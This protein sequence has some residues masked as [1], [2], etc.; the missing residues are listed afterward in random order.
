MDQRIDSGLFCSGTD[1]DEDAGFRVVDRRRRHDE[2]EDETGGAEA[3]EEY[4][5]YVEE[6]R[7]R[8]EAAEEKLREYIAAFREEKEGLDLLR[9]RLEERAEE[10]A[11]EAVG[12]GF[13]RF[14]EVAENLERA[15]A[16]APPEDPLR[17]GV[18]RTHEMLL[19]LLEE[20]GLERLSPLGEEFD[21]REAEAVL[22]RECGEKEHG[23]VV[24]VLRPGFR[25]HEKVLRA[26]Q[27]VVGRHEPRG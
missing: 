24:E 20:Q 22:T 6:L 8:A 27:V 18:A 17:E 2:E 4:P 23:C 13:G 11:R 9:K 25:F 3:R 10:R 15:L 21:P 14:L 5:A 12:R 19:A 1:Q 7:G 16:H 26:A